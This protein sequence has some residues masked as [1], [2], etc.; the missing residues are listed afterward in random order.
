M[1]HL[2]FAVASTAAFFLPADADAEPRPDPNVVT[3][4]TFIFDQR[5]AITAGVAFLVEE[6][7][8]RYMATAYHVLGP[9]GGL[10]TRISPRDVPREVKAIVGL[11]LGDATT[12]IMGTPVLPV[13][14][15]RSFDDAGGEA[16][17][18]FASVPGAGGPPGLKLGD[19]LPKVGE[20]VWLFLR[21]V[22]RDRPTLYPATI[23]EATA[24]YVQYTMEEPSLNLRASSGAPV[25]NKDG[26]VV[27]MHL[28]YGTR[29]DAL[30]C[31]ATPAPAIR[32]RLLA[33][34]QP[35]KKP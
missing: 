34:K 14:D 26:L 35:D 6:E 19:K 27:A 8:Q 1:K 3:L 13:A 12:V 32:Q 23:S 28:G 25:L 2:L 7:G 20:R 16:D 9:A 21:L 33:A 5:H 10:K 30:V 17:L 4:P 24:T 22:D 31:V 15:A 18:T 29:S 11:C